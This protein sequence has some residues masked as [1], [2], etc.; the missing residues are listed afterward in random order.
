MNTKLIAIVSALAAAMA[1]ASAA[2]AGGGGVRLGFGA[3]LGTFV[4]TPA[5][6]GGATQKGGT[7]RKGGAH[8]K[9]AAK[10]HKAK[11]A[12]RKPDKPAPRVAKAASPKTETAKT[13][14]VTETGDTPRLTGSSAL[15]QSQT[16][17][18]A[19]ESGET[20]AADVTAEAPADATA[21]AESDEPP[22]D[23][24]ACK[25]FVPAVGMTVSVGC[26]E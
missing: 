10:K 1:A 22:A 21:K 2:E 3:P 18:E 12:A 8:Q 11:Q 6:G 17:V 9:Q 24:G 25:K 7:Y 13:E 16:P 5:Q 14:P 26:G 19:N 23:E 4:A 15:I 20:P